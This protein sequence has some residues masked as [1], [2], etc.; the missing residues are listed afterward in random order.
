MTLIKICGLTRVEDAVLAA[1]LGADFIGLNFHPPSP[2]YVELER[3]LAIRAAVSGRCRVVGVFV[4]A[5]REF[6][7]ARVAALQLDLIQFHGDEDEAAL[8][9]W[10]VPTIRALRLKPD[11]NGAPFPPTRAAYR[12]LDRFHPELFGGTGRALAIQ[13]LGARDLSRVFI[14]GGLTPEN[15]AAV[16]ALNPYAVDVASGVESAPGVKHD[17]KLRSFFRNAKSSR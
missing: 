7:A 13:A 9:G 2:R 8:E 14:S 4:N 12:L 3:A 17:G 16:V 5:E 15:V 1:E 10:A 11:E 6:I